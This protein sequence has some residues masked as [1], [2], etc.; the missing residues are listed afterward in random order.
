MDENLKVI[1]AAAYARVSTDKDDQVN[2]LKSQKSYFAQYINEHSG[3]ILTNVYYDTGISGTQ[4]CGR[5]GFNAMIDEALH[6]KIDLILTK[7]VCRFAR[8]TVDT[9]FYTRKLKEAGVGVIFTIDNIN[10]LDCDGEL[11]LTIMA[12]IAQEESRK[13]SERVKWGQKRRMEQG[14][15]FGGNML[16][17]T[18]KGGVMTINEEE[19]R[20]VRA[21][22]HKYTNEDKG[23]YIIAKELLEEGMY[24]KNACA[25]SAAVI[26]RVLKNEKYVGDL[27]QKKTITPNFLT[28]AKKR[29]S[30]EEEMIYLTDHHEPI[31]DRQLWNRTQARIK[32]RSRIGFRAAECGQNEDKSSGQNSRCWCGGRIYC[33]E[34]KSRFVSR[35]KVRADKSVYRAWRCH[36]AACKGTLKISADKRTTGCDNI[37]LNEKSLLA[38]VYYAISMVPV[39][40][41]R[42]KNEALEE[43]TETVK[44][45]AGRDRRRILADIEMLNQKKK[46]AID[47]MLDKCIS[48]ADL[49]RQL[50]WYDDEIKIL[51]GE[52]KRADQ[53]DIMK[54]YADAI[55]RIMDFNEDISD[56][57]CG[58]SHFICRE[59][60]DRIEIHKDKVV[61]VK[62]KCIPFAIE[63]KIKSGGKMEKFYTEI[64]TNKICKFS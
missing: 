57:Y 46:K 33:A 50:Q 23:T 21:I 51:D 40:F 8:N 48:K 44:V 4:T 16:G 61:V 64:I 54:Q 9:L 31:I 43:A 42:L 25:W 59:T 56:D 38:C 35:V 45:S 12:C 27:C 13:T 62:L 11:R 6:G 19:A 63:M 14:I 28:H 52:F 41:K 60:L 47:L 58:D 49:D 5:A 2:S 20:I 26:L 34:C 17:Y 18:V 3:W 39:D 36:T 24:P 37:S 32:A 30:G 10:T 7:E 15:V 1:R 29:N 55:D 22:F 53:N